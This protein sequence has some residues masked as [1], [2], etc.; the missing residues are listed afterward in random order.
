MSSASHL[1]GQNTNRNFRQI[2]LGSYSKPE[3]EYLK[4]KLTSKR[5]IILIFGVPF[6]KRKMKPLAYYILRKMHKLRIGCAIF[7]QGNSM[8][9]ICER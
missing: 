2:W 8:R 9:K 5:N 6:A 7:A 3:Q 4:S 1:V